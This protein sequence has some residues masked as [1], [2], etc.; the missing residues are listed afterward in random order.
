MGRSVVGKFLRRMGLGR[1]ELLP[2]SLPLPKVFSLQNLI[3]SNKLG[4]VKRVVEAALFDKRIVVSLLDYA[5]VLH[6]ENCVGVL[7]R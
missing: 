1:G 5:S 4:I 6:N 3:L 7:Y 2:R